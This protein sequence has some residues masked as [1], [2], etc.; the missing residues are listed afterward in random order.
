MSEEVCV[1]LYCNDHPKREVRNCWASMGRLLSARCINVNIDSTAINE[2][3]S[4]F[5]VSEHLFRGRRVFTWRAASLDAYR[6]LP[7]VLDDRDADRLFAAIERYRRALEDGGDKTKPL[8]DR[9]RAFRR[10]LVA[11]DTI[12]R[13]TDGRKR[14]RGEHLRGGHND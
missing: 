5:G 4:L 11:R 3:E 6:V 7:A 12:A 8:L 1:L 9:A 13:I 10:A 2:A 14:L